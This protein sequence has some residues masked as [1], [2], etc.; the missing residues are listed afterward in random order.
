MEPILPLWVA[1]NSLSIGR[2]ARWDRVTD[3]AHAT[4]LPKVGGRNRGRSV[5]RRIGATTIWDAQAM[6]L[7]GP[8]ER[9]VEPD[10]GNT[11]GIAA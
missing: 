5:K 11:K 2:A 3:G 10:S 8:R 7:R 4:A 9:A 6:G 1:D